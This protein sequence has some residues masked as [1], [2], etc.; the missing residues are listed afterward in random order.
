[1]ADAPYQDQNLILRSHGI[2]ARYAQDAPPD[3]TFYL[4]EENIEEIEEN[5]VASRLGSLILSKVGTAAKPLGGTAA[6]VHSL[7]K[8]NGLNGN[9]WRYASLGGN[10]YRL[11]GLNPGQ[12]TLISSLLS[13][14][15]WTSVAY[16][17]SETSYPYL[18][19]ADQSVMLKDNGSLSAPQNIGILQPKYPVV[20]QA[21]K[22]DEI[23]LDA[24]QS[25]SYV[26]TGFT[27]FTANQSATIGQLAS[28]VT[29]TGIQEVNITASTTTY[30]TGGESVT[31]TE[32][33]S[34][35]YNQSSTTTSAFPSVVITAEDIVNFSTTVQASFTVSGGGG[36]EHNMVL[37]NQWRVFLECVL[38]LYHQRI[39]WNSIPNT[40]KRQRNRND[41]SR[42]SCIQMRDSHVCGSGRKYHGKW[43]F[44]DRDIWNRIRHRKP[45]LSLSIACC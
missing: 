4:N 40:G 31:L 20:A 18:Y 19:F 44:W 28:P 26:A 23:V 30:T 10:L 14:Q 13:G 6:V 3:S 21:Q 16:A 36:G 8:L 32:S 38:W 33:S 45:H 9:A 11:A 37:L 29:T 27:A 7:S 22:P 43:F 2:M 25:S 1:M 24:F 39:E 15:P 5:S 41:Q 35:N 17:P 34:G 42:R 12:Y